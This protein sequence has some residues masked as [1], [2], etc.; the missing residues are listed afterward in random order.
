LARRGKTE[1]LRDVTVSCLLPRAG[2]ASSMNSHLPRVTEKR[3]LKSPAVTPQALAWDGKHLWLSSRD[4]GTLYKINIE[5]WKVIQEIDPPGIVWAAAAGNDSTYLTIGKGLND[6]RFV[7]RYAPEE[8][9][10]KLFACPDFTGSYLSVDGDQL[11]LSQWYKQQIL[12]MNKAGEI[13]RAIN[14]GA[15]ISGH[16]FVDGLIYV[17]RGKE[18]PNEEWRIARL[19]PRKNEPLVEDIAVVPFPCRSL[20]FDG[21]RF[22]ANHRAA[23]EIVSFTTPQI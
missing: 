2:D 3:R 17:L 13:K 9:F 7:Y 16:T 14:I 8:G 10:S 18:Q 22:W 19:D 23:N 11:R 4:L 12:E 20:T 15:E 21:A 5:R 6:D 1:A